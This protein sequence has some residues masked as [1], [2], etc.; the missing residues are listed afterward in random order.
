MVLVRWS[1]NMSTP[2]SPESVDVTLYGNTLGNVT[3]LRILRWGD[4]PG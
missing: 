1:P 4:F 2:Q 3:K